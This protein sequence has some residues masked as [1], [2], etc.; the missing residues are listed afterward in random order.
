MEP[1]W[2]PVGIDVKLHALCVREF[3]I[4]GPRIVPM[5]NQLR[6]VRKLNRRVTVTISRNCGPL[7]FLLSAYL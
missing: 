4:L 7:R 2:F 1:L 6:S 3:A 5:L